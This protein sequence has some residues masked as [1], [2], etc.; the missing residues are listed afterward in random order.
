MSFLLR[1]FH[2]AVKQGSN[3][4]ELTTLA[5][6]FGEQLFPTP[7]ALDETKIRTV[8]VRFNEVQRQAFI[9][10][11]MFAVDSTTDVMAIVDRRLAL[12]LQS[13]GLDDLEELL[14]EV[15]PSRPLS[16]RRR[17]YVSLELTRS[18][19]AA[20]VEQSIPKTPET[21]KSDVSTESELHDVDEVDEFD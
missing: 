11:H 13:I 15:R 18:E 5:R 16:A 6:E 1:K 10:P 20:Y 2:S 3:K 17:N 7:I 19:Q 8:F 21:L 9:V 14:D 12:F 4:V